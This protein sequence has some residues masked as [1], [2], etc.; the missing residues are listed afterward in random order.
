MGFFEKLAENKSIILF[1]L[2][3]DIIGVFFSAYTYRYD[4]LIN[5]SIGDFFIIPFFMVSFWLF[6]L[7]ALCCFYLYKSR[8]LPSFLGGLSFIYC[9]VYGFGSVLF[10]P[11]F[12]FFVRGVTLYHVWN[13][14]AHGFVGLQSLIFIRH[15]NKFKIF[16]YLSFGFIFLFKDILD[17][18]YSGFLYFVNFIFPDF[19]KTIIIFIIG[20][21][22]I[23]A[24]YL[25]FVSDKRL[26]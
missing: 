10:Y 18:F 26:K 6:F 20:A 12:M 3:L 5:I 2:I 4:I 23:V 13:I 16:H 15:V 7:S 9:C 21:L 1:I 19:L 14:F 24:F 11:L 17:L 25:L 8:K 22:Q